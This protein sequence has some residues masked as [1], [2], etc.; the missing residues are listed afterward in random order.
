MNLHLAAEDYRSNHGR[1]S[2]IRTKRASQKE[3]TMFDARLRRWIDPPMNKTGRWLA[4]KGIAANQITSLGLL[5]GACAGVGN[6]D[7]TLLAGTGNPAVKP[8]DGRA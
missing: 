8:G 1:Y 3:T 7:G 2:L 6:R 4:S 5:L